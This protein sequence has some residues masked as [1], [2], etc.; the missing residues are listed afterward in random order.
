MPLRSSAQLAAFILFFILL[1]LTVPPPFGVTAL[2]WNTFFLFI[3]TITV[4]LWNRYPIMVVVLISLALGMVLKTMSLEQALRGY[5]SSVTWI[6]LMAFIFARSFIK[7]GLG[8]RI[9]LV[10]IR[11]LGSTSLRLGYAFA[12]SDLALAP[13][14]PS[15]TARAGALIYPVARSLAV[16]FDSHPGPKARRIGAYILFTA[17]QSNIVTS[18]LFLT[19]MAANALAAQLAMDTTG[20]VIDW[21]TWFQAASV[22]G[23]CSL[24][25]VPALIYLT[26]PPE[27]KKTP[28]AV[29]FARRELSALGSMSHDE[30]ILA[31]VF[32]LLALTWA[33]SSWHGTSTVAAVFA[34]IGL[35]LVGGVLTRRDLAE[36]SSAWET[37][38]W[39]GGFLS[40]AGAVSDSGLARQF[41]SGSG[42]WLQSWNP[43]LT[44]VLLV[45]AYTYL[46]YLFAGMT[47]QI[48]ALYAVFLTLAVSA[49][50]PALLSALV[51]AF[52]SNLYACLTHYGDGAAPIFFGSGYIEVKDWWK[53]GFLLSVLHLVVWLGVGLI[54]WKWIGVY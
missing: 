16:E 27:I 38:L 9:A 6:I 35:L 44:L 43:I 45:L 29:R 28:E 39:F 36:E 14:T 47:A 48:V 15:N 8:R 52:F 25:L 42:A 11:R 31:V 18:A 20:V 7:T 50:A 41:L 4:I 1:A 13:V 3:G 22:P 23:F 30:K 5:S 24:L 2:Q 49:G 37:F 51:L 54:W 17:Y 34:A 19:A 32:V 26:Y 46:H 40:I 53:I 33:T 12:L 21:G 10:L